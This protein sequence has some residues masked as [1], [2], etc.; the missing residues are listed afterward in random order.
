MS[1][2]MDRRLKAHLLV[3]MPKE[4]FTMSKAIAKFL[5]AVVAV[6]LSSLLSHADTWTDDAGYTWSHVSIYGAATI[7]GVSPAEGNIAIPSA[8]D[9]RNV[10][11]IVTRIGDQAF[12]DCSGL[13]GVTIPDSVTS[14]GDWAFKGCSG[15][16]SVTIP[17]SVTS[18]GGLAFYG[19]SGLTSVTIPDSVTSIGGRAFYGCSGLTGVTIPDSVTS[20][21]DYAFYGCSGLTSV[22]IPNSVTSIGDSAFE[23]CSGLAGV[24]IP[25]SVTSIGDWAFS[26]CSELKSVTISASVTSI[27]GGAFSRCSNL[28]D[29]SVDPQNGF[30]VFKNGLLLTKDGK[31]L[32]EGINSQGGITIPDSVTSIGYCAF[33]DCSGL[34]SVTIPNTV[35]NIGYNAFYGCSGLTSVT[36]PDSVTS[37][38]GLAFYGCNGLTSVTIPD[39]ATSIGGYAFY[40]CSGLTSVTIPDSVT[41]IGGYAFYGCSGLTGVTIGNGVTSIGDYA[42]KGCSGLTGVTIGNGVTSIG[43]SAFYGC[44]GLTGVTIPDSVTSIGDHAFYG[45]SGLTS[46]TIPDSVTSIGGYAFHGCSGLTSV[47]I[48]DSVTSIGDHAFHGCS[49]LTS[50]TIGIGVTRIGFSCFFG[51]SGLASVTAPRH[52]ESKLGKTLNGCTITYY[53]VCREGLYLDIPYG[54]AIGELPN[55]D[56]DRVG[57]SFAGW[58][59]EKDGGEQV[60]PE[61]IVNEDM[62]IYAQW[63]A[64]EY[65]VTFDWAGGVVDGDSG[66]MGASRSTTFDSAYGELP[67]ARCDGYVF[68]GWTLDGAA[69]TAE[70]IVKTASDHTLTA[71]WGIQVGNGI[72]A[73]MVCD[74]SITLGAPLVPPTGEVVIPAEI[75]GRPVA[76][77]TA[78]A[79][80]EN[81]AVTGVTIPA[82]VTDIATGSMGDL[83][84]TVIVGDDEQVVPDEIAVNVRKVVFAEGVTRIG[85]QLVRARRDEG[86]ASYRLSESRNV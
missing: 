41:S 39:S 51:C 14:I 75:A 76:G 46:V 5:V 37:I 64:N 86:I 33:E 68:L 29:F 13:T 42:F 40:G 3:S 20:I 72:W 50:V 31:M 24:T 58:F 8:I 7:T 83:P 15:L 12:F 45:C 80:A 22:T 73:A 77:I 62:S 28:T 78:A 53:T 23:G 66:V 71:K 67:T 27:G 35:T 21:G 9:G 10:T 61:T 52:L 32:V 4:Y 81:D 54:E 17:D 85:G 49:G 26:D 74:D 19:C 69:V 36:I 6:S 18:I 55:P 30:Y 63:T 1:N 65:E 25:D 48:P 44:S 56:V 43:G 2:I 60:S 57:Y 70:T 34:T 47:T 38:G 16:T 84:V 79:F 11:H 82:S 59:T